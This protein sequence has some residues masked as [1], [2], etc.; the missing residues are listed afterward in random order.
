MLIPRKNS[1]VTHD[2]YR[3]RFLR[4]QKAVTRIHFLSLFNLAAALMAVGLALS[5]WAQKRLQQSFLYMY[6]CI[7]AVLLIC[8]EI[9]WW[10][11]LPSLNKFL[12]SNFGLLYG[13]K[14]KGVFLIFMVPY[15]VTLALLS[16]EEDTWFSVLK[17][18]TAAVW[19]VAGV[20][21][22]I[23]SCLVPYVDEVYEPPTEGLPEHRS[24]I[25]ASPDGKIEPAS[26]VSTTAM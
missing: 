1:S 5:S 17:W 13:L 10:T 22:L 9:V 14:G 6:M 15:L 20:I 26:D 3:C 21:V 19:L 16:R 11:P 23:F 4:R 24:G 12:R 25:E 2:A 18:F 7:A 8:S